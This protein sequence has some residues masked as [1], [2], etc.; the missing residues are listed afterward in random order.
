M[1]R[2][3]AIE[4][5]NFRGI[6]HL[7]WH[8]SPGVNCLIGPGDSGKSTVLDAI[9]M[10]LGA[11]RS[12]P[13]T[14]ADFH[15]LDV[16]QP[17]VIMATLGDLDDP[18]RSMDSFGLYLRGF[19]DVIG[20]EDEP[21]KG[22]ETVLTVRFEVGADLEPVWS[23]YSERASAQGQTR[24]L[25]W[26]DR[27]RLAPTRMGAGSDANLAWRRGS[28]LNRLTEEKAD[29]SAALLRAARD[30]RARF[31]D[32]RVNQ[33][34]DA[35]GIVDRTAAALGIP[36][37]GGSQALLD[38]QSISF[39]GGTVSL[40]DDQG[41][42][43]RALGTGS[44]R[45][46]VAGLQREAASTA[47]M[48]IID[49]LEH[50]LEPH[51]VIRLLGSLGAKEPVPPLQVF[52]TTHSPVAVRELS[53]KQLFM[54][55]R[56]SGHLTIRDIGDGGDA[57]GAARSFPEAFLAAK[58]I[59]CEGASEVGLLRG[60]D[61]HLAQN[62]QASLMAGGVALVD[63]AGEKNLY[64][65][66]NPFLAL[67]YRTLALRDDDVPPDQEG[68]RQFLSSGGTLV[69]WRPGRALE[70]ELFL[71]LS[72]GAAV[73]LLERAVELLGDETVDAHIRS[74][75]GGKETL[76]SCRSGLTPER[77]AC[78]GRASRTKRAGWF[79]SVTWMQDAVVDIVAPD[80]GQVDPGFR[81]LVSDVL[82]WAE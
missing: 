65:R 6:R 42:P 26:S 4:I 63:A 54:V 72:D 7:A 39:S 52:A 10:C 55:R 62:G 64:K 5:S 37:G 66:A 68:E 27:V 34:A 50:G 12:L 59:V 25:S 56:S 48:V 61:I 43:L 53:G 76:A 45:L 21:G 49:E 47:S 36:V 20:V 28:V 30:A 33:L 82:A 15:G 67:G 74:A 57:Q 23:L 8:P 31:G 3:R 60:L 79:K 46:L 81:A 22:C 41:V 29:A 70:D 32:E 80:V 13:L 58:V 78:L 44:T 75:S 24:S 2:I 40:H 38:A 51:R 14:D 77:R 69:H 35:L 19:T 1:A 11:R 9:D 73:L 16:A 18:L 71:S 17:I